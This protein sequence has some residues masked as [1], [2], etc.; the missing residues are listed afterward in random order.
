MQGFVS[1][2]DR[3]SGKRTSGQ[4][5]KGWRIG[6][7]PIY[8]LEIYLEGRGKMSPRSELRGL[9]CILIL[10]LFCA[11][12]ILGRT[13]PLWGDLKPGPH[14]VG[15][16]T[17]EKYDYSRTLR[18]KYDYFGDPLP[19]EVARPIQT[20]IWYPAQDSAIDEVIE[21]VLGEYIFP[22]PEDPEFY[23][24]VSGLQQ[25]ELGL[26]AEILGGGGLVLD[27]Q[28]VT[29]GAIR[30]A[31][32]NEEAFPLI[33]Y[34][35]DAGHSFSD[36]L[37]LCEY[38]ASHGYIVAATGFM[39]AMGV[40]PGDEAADLEAQVQDV[41]FLLANISE[42][43]F[44]NPGKT[45]VIG[46]GLGG[47]VARLI[48]MRDYRIDAVV[49][50]AGWDIQT[51]HLK[52]VRQNPYYNARRAIMPCLHIFNTD[53]QIF[54]L[55]LADSCIYSDSYLVEFSQAP[56]QGFTA[57]SAIDDIISEEG[58][59]SESVLHP[60]YDLICRRVLI[61]CDA[62]LKDSE[63]ALTSLAP[64]KDLAGLGP[65]V[66]SHVKAQDVPPTAQQFLAIAQSQPADAIALY[67]KFN[68]VEPGIINVPEQT[69]NFL[70]YQ[71]LQ[72]GQ[73]EEA[74]GI[75]R[76]NAESYPNSSNVWDS[77]ADGLLAAGNTEKA[78]ECYKK[79]LEVLP[80]D[81]NAD[82]SL[83]DVLRENAERGLER[84]QGDN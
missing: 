8:L 76:I 7:D 26:L 31:P 49:S 32:P 13:Y 9:F 79:V 35:P 63:T 40:N 50:L 62:Y 41:G 16:K 33:L 68:S 53:D 23:R 56:T 24:F 67:D 39:G 17:I 69:M 10:L 22:N 5:K 60:D 58:I 12:N 19:G 6:G 46:V 83:K 15:F 81:N 61:F 82:A 51:Q 73:S 45:G 43:E 42:V 30:N 36:N 11:G 59:I 48:Q 54:D 57:Y 44:I 1:F 4:S 38:L 3:E 70:G 37:I 28:N 84:L 47:A 71:L 78:I 65:A 34:V 14:Q 21:M 27:V 20:Y 77:Y 2:N 52:T 66:T 74:V 72:N 25:R 55:A 64:E 18:P 80:N 29:M 75:F